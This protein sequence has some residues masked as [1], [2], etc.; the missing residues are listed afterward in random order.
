MIEPRI[1]AVVFREG[2]WW[3]IQGLEYDFVTLAR[4]LEDVPS[5]IQQFFSLLIVGS[6]Q[7]GVEPFHGYSKAPR[8]FWEMYDRAEPGTEALTPIEL[9][10]D[11]G[12]APIVDTRL[13][14]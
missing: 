5:S 6:Q 1:R 2:D 13:A 3:I 4:R 8:R 14:A 11:F 12:T 7:L 9:R 10:E